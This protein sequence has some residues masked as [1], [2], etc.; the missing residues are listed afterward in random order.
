MNI[1]QC[2]KND[3][4]KQDKQLLQNGG[5]YGKEDRKQQYE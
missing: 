5:T 1:I 4:R 3:C 2:M